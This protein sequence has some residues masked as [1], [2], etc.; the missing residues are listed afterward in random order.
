MKTS[1]LVVDDE[2]AF[3]DSVVRMLRIEGY[4]DI[5]TKSNPT[6]VP[7]LFEQKQF[8]IAFLDITMPELDG[9]DLLKIIKAPMP[10]QIY[11]IQK[12]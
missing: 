12:Q 8:D 6:E 4:E 7:D 10:Q 3:L 11:Q 5:T 1:I 2:T 9:L